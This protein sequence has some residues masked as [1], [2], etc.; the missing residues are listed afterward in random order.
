MLVSSPQRSPGYEGAM[1][2]CKRLSTLACRA[3]SCWSPEGW[4]AAGNE[5]SV[6]KQLLTGCVIWAG[7]RRMKHA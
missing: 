1:R 6:K 4:C 2:R 7:G 3:M 5:L